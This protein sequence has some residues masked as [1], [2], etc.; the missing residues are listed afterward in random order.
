MGEDE[1]SYDGEGRLS[2]LFV[3]AHVAMPAD[4]RI[5]LFVEDNSLGTVEERLQY[6]A[7]NHPI[8]KFE[9]SIMSFLR[10]VMD[11]PQPPVLSQLE[12]GKLEGLTPKQT[13]AFMMR[14]GV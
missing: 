1:G 10:T 5:Q 11:F 12:K 4:A 13:R 7:V 8:D 2:P 14:C 3:F 6:L 9:I